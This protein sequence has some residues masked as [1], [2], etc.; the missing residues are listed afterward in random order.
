M[1]LLSAIASLAILAISQAIVEGVSTSTAIYTYTPRPTPPAYPASESC[2]TGTITQDVTA[3]TLTPSDYC[4]GKP[5][6][7]TS[8]GPLKTDIIA[9]VTF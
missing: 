7:L 9:G 1:K 5:Y 8:T 2:A 4:V 6:T 3:F